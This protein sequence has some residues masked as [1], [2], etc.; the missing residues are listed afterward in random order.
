MAI[1]T[2]LVSIIFITAALCSLL[3]TLTIKANAQDYVNG[4]GVPAFTTAQSVELGFVNV[5]NGNLH[6]ELPLSS[7][8]QRGALRLDEKLV[9]DSRIWSVL[10][11]GSSK[12]WTPHT[13]NSGWRFESVAQTGSVTESH[14]IYTC[15]SGTGT[16]DDYSSF[17][18]NAP[19]GTNRMF[20]AHTTRG[21][22]TDVTANDAFA[23]DASGYHM[24][25]TNYTTPYVVAPDGTQKYPVLEDT[26]G[27]YLNKDV[28]GNVVDTLART[29]VLQ[30]ASGSTTFFDILN[31]QGT[32][33]RTTAQYA[34]INV[35]T[36]FSQPG[37]TESST[38]LSV[39]TDVFLPDGTSYHFTYDSYGELASTKLPTGATVT[40]GYTNFTDSYGQINRWLSSRLSGGTYSYTPSVITTC[41]PGAQNCQQKVVHTKPGGDSISYVFTLNGGAWNATATYFN[42]DGSKL[43]TVTNNFDLSQTC[44]GCTGAA[45]VHRV[46]QT[47]AFPSTG[48]T[49]STKQVQYTYA[50]THTSVLTS[51]K[52]WKFYT[53]TPPAAPD[54]ESDIAYVNDSA[55]T[56]K[57]MW[58][59]PSSVT[60]KD[61]LGNQVSQTL[62]T[63][64]RY[65]LTGLTAITGV[66]HHDDVGYSISQPTRGNLTTVQQW[67]SGTT[68]LTTKFWWST[69]GQKLQRADPNNNIYSFG[70]TDAFYN[71]NGA[72]PPLATTLA[73]P[74]NA[75]L[76]QLISPIIGSQ[77]FAYYYGSGKQAFS[78]DQNGDTAYSHYLDS[79]DRLTTA[80]A[81]DGGWS[82]AAYTSATVTD[83]YT[84]LTS[85]T[86]GPTCASCV[87]KETTLDS[88]G[89][90]SQIALLSDPDGA[91]FTTTAYDGLG[92]VAS[93]KNPYRTTT[94]PTYGT[95]SYQYDGLDRAISTT[96][97]DGNIYQKLFGAKVVG[98]T[99]LCSPSVYGVG[100]PSLSV[101][102]AKKQRQYWTDGFGNI[103]EVDEPNAGNVPNVATCYK[104]DVAG[105]L[106]Q[107]MQQAQTRTY[108]YDALGR[109]TSSSIPEAGTTMYAYTTATG[110]LCAGDPSKSCQRTDARGIATAYSY[111]ALNRLILET[112]SDGTPTV[113]Y[114]Y[115]ETSVWGTP[116]QNTKGRLTH[117]TS[118]GKADKIF[119]YDAAGRIVK[120]VECLPSNCGTSTY[121]T[122]AT[123]DLSGNMTSLKYPSGRVVNY[124]YTNAGRAS[125]VTLASAGGQ[126]VT[127]NY[128]TGL[129]YAPNGAIAGV[130]L[131]N[132]IAN[133]LTGSYTYNKRWQLL[134]AAVSSSLIT[135][136]SHTYSFADANGLN[137]GNL[138]G[139]T[140]NLSAARSEALTY[141]TL[142]RVAAASQSAWGLS[143]AYDLY[144]NL[145]Q[146][147]VT[148]GSA[149]GL[150]VG[151]NSNNQISDPGYSYDASG[152]L[153]ADA[154]HTYAYN[155]LSEMTSVDNG[156]ATYAYDTDGVRVRKDVGA[157]WTEY[158][159]FGHNV[160]AEHNQAGTWSDYIAFQ[161]K[162]VIRADD[163]DRAVHISGSNCSACG[164]QSAQF[165]VANSGG[166]NGYVVQPGDRLFLVQ[167][168]ASGS[169][170]GVIISFSDGTDTSIAAKD[171][172]THLAN[173]DSTQGSA[174]YRTIDLS[175]FAGKTVTAFSFNAAA[176]TSA[177]AWNITYEQVVLFGADGT[178]H[179]IFSGQPTISIP[180]I[181]ATSGV[182]NPAYTVDTNLNDAAMPT[183]TTYYM[184]SDHIGSSRLIT[185]AYGYPVWQ[186]TYLPFGG[187]Y[188]P[189]PSVDHYKFA[190]YEHDDE[191]GLENANIR[192]LSSRL[193]R[194]T[195]VDPVLARIYNPQSF[196]RYTY[197]LN[198]PKRYT[199]STGATLDDGSGDDDSGYG[200]LVDGG[201]GGG[202]GFQDCNSAPA[203]V[204]CTD[205]YS[206]NDPSGSSPDDDPTDP[207]P[208][209]TS[210][211]S[212]GPTS[213]PTSD[214]TPPPT[215]CTSGAPGC[216]TGSN[217]VPQNCT[218]GTPGCANL[219]APPTNQNQT[220]QQKP[221]PRRNDIHDPCT[222]A[223]QH[224]NN[225]MQVTYGLLILTG[226]EDP[227][228]YIGVV[229]EI[230]IG[231][232][233]LFAAFGGCH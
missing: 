4:T 70:Y 1:R 103:I 18:W 124:S 59:L 139:D 89:R 93:V 7:H 15:P 159:R 130:T 191:S 232:E 152:N 156:A 214:P 217:P 224:F 45:Y 141:D 218:P 200:P 226:P 161:G 207:D 50:Q 38:T 22:G 134:N 135:A 75:Y 10:D 144:G 9:Y 181:N 61:S 143:F 128:L 6:L 88:L 155:A 222:P 20:P 194:F 133:A 100:Y 84:G 51:V 92:R 184:H 40:Y 67:V 54:R 30:S 80:L 108:T 157:K 125:Q 138:L 201:V 105:H 180:V 129:K 167:Y 179:P 42:H 169:H 229:G 183:A 63:Y 37:V 48:G 164:S 204:I 41:A 170:G 55:H 104:Y 168:Q 62:Y 16:Y 77:T 145:L 47:T 28:N 230:G 175:S 76:T 231:G 174:H 17:V 117:E 34:T 26:N 221:N 123:Y 220:Q 196:N 185:T 71:D 210:I 228:F 131:D 52:E 106:T 166:L 65:D 78:T 122:Q 110:A 39:I 126:A 68:Y 121:T 87:H 8:P 81:P 211:P 172:D 165:H 182:T 91:T 90:L 162:R 206:P 101:D 99:Q 127:F 198:N 97:A 66:T 154:L 56:G 186:A 33:S 190:G 137:N 109:L 35:T 96:K 203:D 79:R 177:G 120:Q 19:D 13:P 199:D 64:D 209:P 233:E 44:Q 29:P 69:T 58:T 219:P 195:S 85:A 57:N 187:E 216:T 94:E 146:Q 111:D 149:P 24:W 86:P 60:V 72:N 107:V 118:T 153:I 112:F 208:N 95:T 150:I 27:N 136:M 23:T 115:D 21:C 160:I 43:A 171:Q 213:D 36:A 189:Q 98:V 212:T 14:N 193:A 178:V 5:A 46:S 140:D 192:Q 3:L 11:T 119:S 173:D 82:L 12:V 205:V 113:K 102:P 197:T 83:N 215:T 74:T 49:T 53:G 116:L 151:V 142:N 147:N 188:N 2:R 32:R 176:D 202:G 158:I 114:S 31:S 225:A 25:V 227:L 132:G 148:S 163:F 223:G 73:K